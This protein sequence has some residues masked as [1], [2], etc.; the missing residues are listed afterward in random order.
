M[1][2]E[3]SS[4]LLDRVRSFLQTAE[5]TAAPTDFESPPENSRHIELDIYVPTDGPDSPLMLSEAEQSDPSSP[6]SSS[7]SGESDAESNNG[8]GDQ[9]GLDKLRVPCPQ[10][11]PKIEEVKDEIDK[12]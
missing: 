1:G 7:S 3:L 9:I 4:C 11:R 10:K 12:P 5:Q 6:S 8:D 2:C